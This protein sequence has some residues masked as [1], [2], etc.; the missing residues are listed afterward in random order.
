MPIE[1]LDKS[2]TDSYGNSV[3]INNMCG[4]L[5]ISTLVGSQSVVYI[6]YKE[7]P[8]NL[9]SYVYLGTNDVVPTQCNAP[10]MDF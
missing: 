4:M 9:H 6:H 7:S 10:I 3:N 2:R 1:Q 5:N 8:A